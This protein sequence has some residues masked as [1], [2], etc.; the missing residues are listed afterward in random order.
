[1]VAPIYNWVNPKSAPYGLPDCLQIK[2]QLNIDW[3]AGTLLTQNCV[4]LEVLRM[5]PMRSIWDSHYLVHHWTTIYL[6]S[7][8]PHI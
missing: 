2:V 3:M 5:E 6:F 8:S 7:R 4:W 1:M